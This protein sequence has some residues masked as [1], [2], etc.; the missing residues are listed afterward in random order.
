[1]S[2]KILKGKALMIRHEL[3]Q[4]KETD[5]VGSLMAMKRAAAMA[6]E[7]AVRKDKIARL[8]ADESGK[9]GIA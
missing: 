2:W 8:T 3:V 4:V 6:R 7:T 5:R 1:V 9:R